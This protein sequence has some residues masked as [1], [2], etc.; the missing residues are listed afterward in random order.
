MFNLS[1]IP[2]LGEKRISNL[3]EKKINSV[4]DLIFFYPINYLL[5]T[6]Q[7]H[8]QNIFK[9][10]VKLTTYIY[11]KK[12]GN[13]YLTFFSVEYQGK[14][15]KCNSFNIRYVTNKFKKND[16]VW[17]MGKYNSQHNI[18]NVSGISYS[19][20]PTIQPVYKRIP[21]IS[22]KA[23]QRY[24]NNAISMSKPKNLKYLNIIHNPKNIDEL[25]DALF[26]L[27]VDEYRKYRDEIEQLKY[28]YNEQQNN[29]EFNKFEKI[30]SILSEKK[31]KLTESQ[32]NA[33]LKLLANFNSSKSRRIL[34]KGDVGSGKS[35]IILAACLAN[36]VNK[37]QSLI[38]LPT[39][40]L[41]KQM[42]DLMSQ[43]SSSVQ[44][45]T[46]SSKSFNNVDITI[47]TIAIESCKYS[48]NNLSLLIF[49]EQQRFGVDLKENIIKKGDCLNVLEVTATPI[50]R[51]LTQ[52]FYN[53][54]HIIHIDFK[55]DNIKSSLIL[56][57]NVQ[58][59]MEKIDSNKQLLIICPVIE[60]MGD[61]H[62]IIEIYEMLKS[63]NAKYINGSLAQQTIER[64]LS[65][66][67]DGMFNILISTSI[68]EVGINLNNLTQ[69][70]VLSSEHF[71]LSQLHQ[72]RGR[73][74]RLG[75]ISNCYFQYGGND[76]HV[77]EKLTYLTSNNDGD[78]ISIYDMNNRGPGDVL[79][80]NQS[81]DKNF[82][83]FNPDVD[84]D[85]IDYV[86]KCY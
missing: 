55:R 35:Y 78:K 50:P 85:V 8:K 83:I 67:N 1:D 59:I 13:Q 51:T 31:T 38:V 33:F 4:N 30:T 20:F 6:P 71:G 34:L 40:I 84:F 60:P 32:N 68:I 39:K 74:G 80:Q 27:K 48:F 52:S 25:S 47:S 56:E 64:R 9:I 3:N 86:L 53:L 14:K 26:K 69:V 76:S 77:I 44:L 66:F 45:I 2:G 41:A 22:Q 65:E 54:N 62:S 46:S 57:N 70:L 36:T 12:T 16:N 24:I 43:F 29:F 75:Q 17:L 19:E 72:F 73:V 23:V 18:I 63:K 11:S 10:K 15:Y 81:G 28:L 58:S 61:R 79:G 21:N 5:L 37:Q 42:Y 49:D 82:K 7:F